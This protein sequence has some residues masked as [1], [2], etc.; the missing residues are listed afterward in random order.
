M[1]YPA[2][3]GVMDH[4]FEYINENNFKKEIA[5]IEDMQ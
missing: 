3:I 5:K 2:P 1:E 4:T